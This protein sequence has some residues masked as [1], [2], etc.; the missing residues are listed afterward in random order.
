MIIELLNGLIDSLL[1]AILG[2]ENQ[3]HHSYRL[4]FRVLIGIFCIW[5]KFSAGGRDIGVLS[6]DL[7]FSAET[8]TGDTLGKWANKSL[9]ADIC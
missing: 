4:L 5:E 3:Y 7:R 8:R 6:G 9:A 2:S 1:I